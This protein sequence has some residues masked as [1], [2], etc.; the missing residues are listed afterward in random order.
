M[1]MNMYTVAGDCPSNEELVLRIQAGDKNAAELLL[2]QNEGFLTST[3]IRYKN[4]SR[5][6]ILEDLKKEGAIALLDAAQSFDLAHGAQF[7][8]YATPVVETVMQDYAARNS[9]SVCL[10]PNRYYQLRKVAK[11]CAA[12][13]DNSDEQIISKIQT[14]L[15]VSEKV[16]QALL[17][18]YLMFYRDIELDANEYRVSIGGDPAKAYDRRIQRILLFQRIEEV[19]KPRELT[20]V[21]HYHGIG[22]PNEEGMTFQKLAV[23]LNYNGPSG[24]EKAYKAAIRKLKKEL[25]SGAY[26]QWLSIQKA[27]DRARAE[28]AADSGYYATPQ[29]T[30]LDEKNL[31]ERFI[32]EVVALTQVHKIFSEA[33]ENEEK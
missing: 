29:T 5:F 19:L 10:S 24:A 26:G 1:S 18:D 32:C 30:W 8:T 9:L 33:L 15:R 27:I 12:S 7:L 23:Q 11:L 16:A 17:V 28:A 20:L 2:S 21:R 3:A 31:V 25:H 13:D 14:E 4:H 6:S 22:L